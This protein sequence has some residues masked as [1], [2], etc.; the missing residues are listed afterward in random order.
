METRKKNEDHAVLVLI[1]TKIN[2][3]CLYTKFK[4]WPKFFKKIMWPKA[5][6]LAALRE[7][8]ACCQCPV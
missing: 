5:C 8:R 7:E 4:M 2:E 6:T 1:S 3:K